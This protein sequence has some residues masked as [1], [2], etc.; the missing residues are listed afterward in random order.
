MGLTII[1]DVQDYTFVCEGSLPYTNHSGML[2]W[3]ILWLSIFKRFHFLNPMWTTARHDMISTSWFNLFNNLLI[4]YKWSTRVNEK[5]LQK[6]ISEDQWV[7][8]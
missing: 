6:D 8:K 7:A 4:G 1:E 5:L 3:P 2:V